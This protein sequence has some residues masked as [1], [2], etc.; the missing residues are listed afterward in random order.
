MMVI[1]DY[2]IYIYGGF[3]KWG[4]PKW[5]EKTI[6]KW[7]RTGG[8]YIL[9]NPNILCRITTFIDIYYPSI[10]IYNHL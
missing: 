1:W 8:T 10:I 4:Y 7:M 3:H 2:N 6:Y 9:G 5:M